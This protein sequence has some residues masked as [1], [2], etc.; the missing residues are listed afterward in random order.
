MEWVQ[1]AQPGIL[2]NNRAGLPGDFRTPEQSIPHGSQPGRFEACVTMTHSHW[3]Y[4][5]SDHYKDEWQLLSELVSCVAA[6][7]NYLLNVGPDPDGV[8]PLPACERL[9]AMGQWLQVHGE[10]IYGTDR[11]LPDWWDY[12]SGGRITT[13]GDNGLPDRR[14]LVAKRFDFA[15]PAPERCP[16][17]H[18]AGNRSRTAGQPQRAQ[19]AD[20]RAACPAPGNAVQR[21][22]AGVG[23]PGGSRRF[24]IEQFENG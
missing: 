18:L 16:A 13:K 12:F 10:A 15:E 19:T 23:W 20:R 8:I 17:R 14:A 7:G 9:L 2:I 24:I 22:E 5:P 3:G 11:P 6:G 1:A 4:C 21:G